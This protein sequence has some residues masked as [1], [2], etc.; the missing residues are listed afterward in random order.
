MMVPGIPS[1]DRGNLGWKL[2]EANWL[3]VINFHC[4]QMSLMISMRFFFGDD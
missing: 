2:G 4:M 3:G 1:R